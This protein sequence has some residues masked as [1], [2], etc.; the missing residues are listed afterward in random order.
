ML[1]VQV[2]ALSLR[3]IIDRL[4][5]DD[6]G[7][8]VVTDYKTGRAPAPAYEQS[9]FGG[10][11]FYAY[12]CEKVVGVRPVRV[13]LLHLREPL[14]ISTIPSDQSVRGLWQRASAV[15]EAVELACEREDFRP[16][17]GPLCD[18]CAFH[19]YCPAWG[20]DPNAAVQL[21]G[22]TSAGHAPFSERPAGQLT[23]D[24]PGG[25]SEEASVRSPIPIAA[26]TWH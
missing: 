22:T 9:R 1:S 19:A 11:H 16:N 21:A 26:P 6:G 24:R 3:G 15:W 5:L 8:L 4:E 17:P 12:L 13:Q 18:F 2:G 25:G 10:L 23:P 14:A 7:G 20:G